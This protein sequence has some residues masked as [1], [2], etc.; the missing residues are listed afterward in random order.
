MN[1]NPLRLRSIYDLI[2]KKEKFYIPS[3]QRGYR[4]TK[5]QVEDLLIDILE[6]SQ[7]V[8]QN[9]SDGFYCLQPVVVKKNNKNESIWDVIDGQQRLTTIYILLSYFDDISNLLFGN[10]DKYSISYETRN[11][12]EDFL[13]KIRNVEVENIS[14]IDFFHMSLAYITINK[15]FEEKN[16][17]KVDFLNTL[18]RKDE[19]LNSKNIAKNIRVIWYEIEENE[20]NE[21]DIFTRINMGKIPLTNAELIKAL[22]LKSDNE[23][24]QNKQF[25]LATEWDF[26]EYSLQNDE[27]WYFLNS[28]NDKATRIEF[29]FEF[30]TDMYIKEFKIDKLNKSIDNYYTFHVFS[31]VLNSAKKDREEI[32]DDVKN[33]FR[34]FNEWFE[35]RELFHKIGFLINENKQMIK[36]LIEEN[37]SKTKSTFRDFLDEKIKDKLKKDFKGKSID[38]LEFDN[39]KEAIKQTL[40]L[41][42]IVTLLNNKKSNLKFQFDRFKKENWDIEHIRSQNDKKLSKKSDKESWITDMESLGMTIENKETIVEDKNR[43]VFDKLYE[44]IEK[45]FGE[46]K[47]FDKASISN[48][49]LLDAGTNRSYKNAFFPIKRKT[50]LENDMNGIFIPICTRNTFVKYYTVNINS[51]RTWDENDADDYLQALKDTLIKYLPNQDGKDAK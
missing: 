35:N 27:F 33:Y 46:D 41:F 44:S 18:K 20:E 12:S 9:K 26:I 49:A 50:I 37:K 24:K 34:I 19:E 7:N 42:N 29:I 17:N 22:L 16:I 8:Q 40:L 6:F 45:E 25:E 4:W 5:Q 2:E 32:W 51:I 13:K 47:V 38:E 21:I 10:K 11:D 15:W 14:N 30:I 3:Y 23:F 1:E 31:E 43:D 48:L 39:S 28:K 36:V